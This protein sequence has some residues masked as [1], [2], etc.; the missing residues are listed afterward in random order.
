MVKT[1][2]TTVLSAYQLTADDVRAKL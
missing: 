2:V 1:G